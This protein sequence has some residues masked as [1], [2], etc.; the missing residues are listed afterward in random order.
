MKLRGKIEIASL[1][2]ISGV[3]NGKRFD[4]IVGELGTL[5]KFSYLFLDVI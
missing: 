2:W 5:G 3:F 4:K 1:V